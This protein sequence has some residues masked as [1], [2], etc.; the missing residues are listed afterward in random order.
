MR[1]LMFAV[2][3]G[4]CIA[5]GMGLLAARDNLLCQSW[6]GTYYSD[7]TCRLPT[8]NHDWQPAER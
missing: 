1:K 2:V 7:D 5:A 6:G 4:V 3:I 8:Q